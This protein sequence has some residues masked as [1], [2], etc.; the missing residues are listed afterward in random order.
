MARRKT[1]ARTDRRARAR[2]HAELVRD[3]ERLA[4]L[5]E[6][7]SPERPLAVASAAQVEVIA[8]ARPCPLCK[9]TTHLDEHAAE[10]VGGVRLRVVRV[11]CTACGVGRA[12][13]FRIADTP[14]N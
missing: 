11:A 4:R 1:S 14:L 10:V 2:A 8:R 3:L 6:G 12:L 7:G 5:E 9:A 13:Y